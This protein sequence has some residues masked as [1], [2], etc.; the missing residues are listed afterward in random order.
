ME[1][2]EIAVKGE[3]FIPPCTRPYHFFIDTFWIF[4]SSPQPLSVFL[5]LI[6]VAPFAIGSGLNLDLTQ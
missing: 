4:S 3:N 2:M 6:L 1:R 5:G